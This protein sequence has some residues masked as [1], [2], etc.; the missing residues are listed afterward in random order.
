MTK[1]LEHAI[2]QSGL[3]K[4]HIAKQLGISLITFNRKIDNNMDFNRDQLKKLQKV[5]GL[6][7]SEWLEIFFNQ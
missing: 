4:S 2:E 5:L 1:K 6:S 7:K 3:K